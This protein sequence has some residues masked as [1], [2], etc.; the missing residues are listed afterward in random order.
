VIELPGREAEVVELEG[1]AGGA[2]DPPPARRP[3]PKTRTRVESDRFV[4]EAAPDGTLSL[5][6]KATGRRYER[7]H[8][9]EDEPDMGDLYNFCPVDGAPVWRTEGVECRLLADGP[10]VWELELQVAAERPAGLDETEPVVLRAVTIA[11]LVR[12]SRRV[13]FRTTIDNPA[14]DHRLRATFAVSEPDGDGRT[15]VRAESAFAL[16][17]RPAQ[18]SA[19]IAEWAEPPDPTQHTLGVAAV[20]PLAL[21]TKGLPEYEARPNP[22]G[23]ELCLTL[24]RCVGTISKPSGAISTRPIGAGPDVPTPEGQCLGRHELEYALLLGADQLD[25][26]ELL[27][28]SQDYRRGFLVIAGTARR[29]APPL[30]LEGEVVFSCLKG[31]ED[32]DGL[33]LRCFNPAGSSVLARVTGPFE[34]SRARLDETGDEPAC[35]GA[36]EL[37]PHQIATLRLRPA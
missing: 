30:T 17:R 19:P 9:L 8:G 27:R 18:P 25:D 28:E 7:L 33:I 21:L 6:D 22:A 5:T 2:V 37:G 14:R 20:G 24:L 4:L 15:P 11:R 3:E 1:F 29:F 31:A 34:L 23:I 16:V 10:L 32:G 36:V 35:D 26:V 12:G 13:E